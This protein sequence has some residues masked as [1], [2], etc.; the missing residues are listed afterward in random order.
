MIPCRS[1]LE[2]YTFFVLMNSRAKAK[3]KQAYTLNPEH[4]NAKEATFA[5]LAAGRQLGHHVIPRGC[6]CYVRGLIKAYN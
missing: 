5:Q 6:C 4:P 1:E 2:V 3:E